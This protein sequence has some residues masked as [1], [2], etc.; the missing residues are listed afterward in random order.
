MN[1][2]IEFRISEEKAAQWFGPN[3]GTKTG[4]WF[5]RKLEFL[6]TD[7]RMNIIWKAERDFQNQGRWKGESR[8]SSWRSRE[9]RISGLDFD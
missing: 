9:L 6:T 1:E 8:L 5:V 7:P 3:Q 4:S 2:K